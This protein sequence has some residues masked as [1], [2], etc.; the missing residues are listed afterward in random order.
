[1]QN[2]EKHKPF[3]IRGP[4]DHAG[5]GEILLSAIF[6]DPFVWRPVIPEEICIF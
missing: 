3:G 1:M 4:T 2:H 5:V 6:L